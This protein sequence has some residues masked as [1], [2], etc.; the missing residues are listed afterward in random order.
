MTNT[1]TRTQATAALGLKSRSAFHYLRRRYPKY[2]ITTNQGTGK[3][4][5][6]LYDKALIDKFIDLR[7]ALRS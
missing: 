6:T 3:G 2:F 7:K 1:Y 4:N 5:V